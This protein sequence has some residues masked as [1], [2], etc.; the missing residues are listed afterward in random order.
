MQ[1][2]AFLMVYLMPNT[3]EFSGAPQAL[4]APQP[5]QSLTIVISVAMINAE[6][7]RHVHVWSKC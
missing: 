1:N 5:Y 4:W 7:C 2:W 6:H 3:K